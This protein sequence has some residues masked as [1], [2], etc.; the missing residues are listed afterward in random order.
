[1]V[2]QGHRDQ[3]LFV[4]MFWFVRKHKLL[5]NVRTATMR[6]LSHSISHRLVKRGFKEGKEKE[7]EIL[8]L[9]AH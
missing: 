9:T 7:R 4:R 5:S 2:G 8:D 3:F 6:I 1:M